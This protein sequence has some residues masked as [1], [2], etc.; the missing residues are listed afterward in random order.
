M[1]FWSPWNHNSDVG[2]TA[3]GISIQNIANDVPEFERV[4]TARLDDRASITI[5]MKIF[6]GS[7]LKSGELTQPN[8]RWI[9]F[10]P[11]AIADKILDPVLVPLVQ[12]YVNEIYDLDHAFRENET[13]EYT[14][15]EGHKWRMVST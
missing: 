6:M 2:P 13:T 5:R 1:S 7:I 10:D 11:D 8:G 14:D 3:S 15:N 9:M 12:K 4:Y